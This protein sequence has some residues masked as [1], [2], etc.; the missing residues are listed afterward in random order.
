PEVKP[1]SADGTAEAICGRVGR[2]QRSFFIP[3]SFLTIIPY[4]NSFGFSGMKQFELN[5]FFVLFFN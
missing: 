3:S 4:D 5:A 1:S 2:R